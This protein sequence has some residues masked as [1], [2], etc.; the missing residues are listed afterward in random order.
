MM[1]NKLISFL[2]LLA[3]A[4]APLQAASKKPLTMVGATPGQLQAGDTIIVNASITGAASINIPQGTAPTSPSN[5]DIWTTTGG[6]FTRINGVTQGPLAAPNVPLTWSAQQF[7]GTGTTSSNLLQTYAFGDGG[8]P[9][10][11]LA[12]YEGSAITGASFTSRHTA[13][14]KASLGS[15]FFGFADGTGV[16]A[17]NDAWGTYAECRAYAG[18]TGFCVGQEIDIANIRGVSP[19]PS[20]PYNAYASGITTALHLASGGDCHAGKPCYNPATGATDLVSG[21]AST[22]LMIGTN[23]TKFNAGIVFQC[24]SIGTTDCANAGQGDALRL[25]PGLDLKYYSPSNDALFAFGVNSGTTFGGALKWSNEGLNVHNAGGQA[26]FQ[27][28]PGVTGVNGLLFNSGNT[29]IA[30]AIEAQGSDTNVSIHLRPKGTGATVLGSSLLPQSI[31][32]ITTSVATA[33][34]SPVITVSAGEEVN[35]RPG[36]HIVV[37]GCSSCDTV[38]SRS[39][40]AITLN[41]NATAT[42]GSATATVGLARYDT[43]SSAVVNTL[44][45]DTILVG[46]AAQAY[47]DWS[48]LYDGPGRYPSIGTMKVVSRQGTRSAF[49]GSRLSDT[50][51]NSGLPLMENV[52]NMAILDAKP[53]GID[54]GGW[55]IYNESRLLSPSFPSTTG[56]GFISVEDSI[57]SEWTSPQLDPYQTN[58]TGYTENFRPDC[59]TGYAASSDCST[60]IHIINNGGRY[61]SGIIFSEDALNTSGGTADAPALA[62]APR[63]SLMWYR[64]AGNVAWS[65]TSTATSGNHYM[66]LR[67][68]SGNGEIFAAEASLSLNGASGS[69]NRAV[70]YKSGDLD[71]WSVGATST[72]QSGGN[73]GADY[74]IARFNDAGAYVDSPIQVLRSSGDILLAAPVRLSGYTVAALPTCNINIKGAMAHATDLAAVT[75]N[76]TPSGGG[77]N[78]APVYCNGTAWTV[79]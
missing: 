20:L 1:L 24:G 48:G 8:S 43:T 22:A 69:Q 61:K 33:S 17:P 39:G 26:L 58:V 44:G 34:G 23:R 79:H 62:M 3:L 5:G 57:F 72:A 46:A 41:G 7:F 63:H 53:A 27:F 64:A 51:P 76:A 78:D 9:L 14:G 49:F 30:P 11:S 15:V 74:A 47:G 42:S 55:N 35:F 31:Q 70:R 65:I 38:V 13:A 59:G 54:G 75:Y 68:T 4:A 37:A 25:Y 45:A 52:V 71:L 18:S 73:A 36:D 6:I 32:P 2:A 77:A 16:R 10:V 50:P 12:P 21:D 40:T 66:T 67:D 56:L 19:V 29:T 60:A 28:Y